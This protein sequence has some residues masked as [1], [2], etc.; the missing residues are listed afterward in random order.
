MNISRAV[1]LPGHGD[2]HWAVSGQLVC[3]LPRLGANNNR[4]TD[5]SHAPMEQLGG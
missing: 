2:K 5:T 3:L 4:G 1:T